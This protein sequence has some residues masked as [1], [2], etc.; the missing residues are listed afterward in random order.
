MSSNIFKLTPR[1]I[2]KIIAEERQKL[3]EEKEVKA[4]KD[5]KKLLE[6]LNLYF[7]IKR[8]QEKSNEAINVLRK[9]INEN[10]NKRK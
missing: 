5:K 9:F 3:I 8:Q 1:L 6:A 2:K 10:K 7:K 4:S